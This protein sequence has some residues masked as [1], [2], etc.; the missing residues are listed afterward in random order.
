MFAFLVNEEYRIDDGSDGG[1][2]R[3]FFVQNSE[4][5]ASALKVTFFHYRHVCGNHIVWVASNVIEVSVRHIGD[6]AGRFH[7]QLAESVN[8]YLNASAADETASAS[9]STL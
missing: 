7:V 1:L 5:G 2:A 4:V 9:E 3:G 6:V 8:K